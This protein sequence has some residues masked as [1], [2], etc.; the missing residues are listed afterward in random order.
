[1]KGKKQGHFIPHFISTFLDHFFDLTSF[2]RLGQK[3]LQ[4]FHC[5]FGLFE[6]TKNIFEINL[7]LGIDFVPFC[8]SDLDNYKQVWTSL[9]QFEQI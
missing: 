3:F 7:P 9:D 1:M 6:D 5:F 4:K 2:W 8:L